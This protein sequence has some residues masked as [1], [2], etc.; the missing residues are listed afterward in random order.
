VEAGAHVEKV[1]LRTLT[2]APCVACDHCRKK[3]VCIHRDDMVLLLE[4]MSRSDV[5]VLGTPVHWYAPSTLFKTFLDRWYGGG[6]V[7]FNRAG[8][9]AV[10]V[11]AMEAENQT[12]GRHT[13][14]MIA[15]TLGYLKMEH[16]ATVLAA[17]VHAPGAVRQH[18]Q[19]LNAAYQ[20]GWDSVK[21]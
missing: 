19:V 2:I 18:P 9:R 7:I 13:V 11:A 21:A 10:I 6:D 1:L 12:V 17:S 4:K 14:G 15:D 16:L 3:G 20:A 8:Q 5:W